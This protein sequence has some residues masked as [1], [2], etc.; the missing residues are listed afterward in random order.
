MGKKK[1]Y[2]NI[3]VNSNTWLSKDLT[4]NNYR[5]LVRSISVNFTKRYNN[6]SQEE[7]VL[8]F[9]KKFFN[10]DMAK[11]K[12][13]INEFVNLLND[14][15][16]PA[17][18]IEI[19]INYDSNSFFTCKA[20]QDNNGILTINF[21]TDINQI[22]L[23]KDFIY[24]GIDE[25]LQQIYTKS[26]KDFFIKYNNQIITQLAK[27]A[28]IQINQNTFKGE[29]NVFIK[30]KLNNTLTIYGRTLK[31]LFQIFYA[32]NALLN[33]ENGTYWQFK[34]EK[35]QQLYLTFVLNDDSFFNQM[36]SNE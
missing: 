7:L 28:E 13:F 9:T 24:N 26:I 27:D 29:V 35:L 34:N 5:K 16:L 20:I 1:Y 17:D 21:I 33:K 6:Q 18:Y 10:N 8:I 30:Y 11:T 2:A 15:H 3:I 25:D 32:H 22:I 19:N 12:L 4:S 23:P 36:Y 31:E 14:I